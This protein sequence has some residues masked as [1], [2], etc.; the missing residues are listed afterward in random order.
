MCTTSLVI[1][2]SLFVVAHGIST[3]QQNYRVRGALMCG[4]KPA[5]DV[6]V[7]LVDDDFGEHY[8]YKNV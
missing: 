2:I 8:E 7:K 1:L 5:K 6:Q 4:E 3:R